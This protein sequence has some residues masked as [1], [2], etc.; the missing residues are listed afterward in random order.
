[1]T[2]LAEVAVELDGLRLA[3]FWV[4]YV[5]GG[6]EHEVPPAEAVAVRFEQAMPVRRSRRAYAC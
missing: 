3:A 5:D 4:S 1:V 6:A 2:V